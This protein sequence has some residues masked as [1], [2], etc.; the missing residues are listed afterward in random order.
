MDGVRGGDLVDVDVEEING[1][2]GYELLL[3]ADIYDH[4]E[5]P[6]DRN[7]ERVRWESLAAD[8]SGTVVAGPRDGLGF[9]LQTE[10]R[11]SASSLR[12]NLRDEQPARSFSFA[13]H[14]GL[15]APDLKV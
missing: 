8:R 13:L 15:Q 2:L 11:Q 6:L 4:L 9:S 7:R 3:L 12:E 1:G 14:R 10:S 5:A